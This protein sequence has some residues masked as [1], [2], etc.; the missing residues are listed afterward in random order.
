MAEKIC[1]FEY[2]DKVTPKK[3]SFLS[4]E[5]LE[6]SIKIDYALDQSD[7][8]NKSKVEKF[9]VEETKKRIS[10]QLSHLNSWI[11]DKSKLVEKLN[12]E[13]EKAEKV[14]ASG[15]VSKTDANAFKA[16]YLEVVKLQKDVEN[17]KSDYQTIVNNWA[18]GLEQQALIALEQAL[19]KGRVAAFNAKKAKL[20][21]TTA[22]RAVLVIGGISLGV[23]ALIL[24][25]GALAPAFLGLAIAGVA[26][27]GTASL[28]SLGKGCKEV[29]DTETRLLK[30]VE[31]D[32][33]ELQ[34]VLD[35]ANSSRG[36]M[37]GHLSDMNNLVKMKEDK[38]AKLL[39]D[40]NKKS[41]ELTSY[42]AEQTKLMAELAKSASNK[43]ALKKHA[44]N[45]KIVDT[46]KKDIATARKKVSK[47]KSGM[48]QSKELERS[49]KDIGVKLGD[50][51]GLQPKS[52][53][54]QTKQLLST[55][56]GWLQIADTVG[57]FTGGASGLG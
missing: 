46:L 21:K 11:L 19:K 20:R 57:A 3:T 41:A 1:T 17:L 9:F 29:Y 43:S 8:A 30:Q 52:L 53:S 35:K 6:I 38:I 44:A 5:P 23:A 22:L 36:K 32:L 12:K 4:S 18:S 10:K 39:V 47:V 54:A 13:A 55:S 14:L 51:A 2:S 31:S 49:L 25:G 40:I 33:K 7:V 15:K 37:G 45:S 16:A 48:A 26:I 34:S 56:E 42:E 27:S 24:S 50:V 28:V